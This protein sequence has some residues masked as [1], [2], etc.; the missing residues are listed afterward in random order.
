MRAIVISVLFLLVLFDAKCQSD[1][2]AINSINCD[3]LITDTDWKTDSL[4]KEVFNPWESKDFYMLLK[5][6]KVG[7]IDCGGC[8]GVSAKIQFYID[9]EGKI[10]SIK[11]LQSNKCGF[12][13]DEKFRND[14]INSFSTLV[15]PDVLRNKCYQF[16]VGRRL[17]C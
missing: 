7:K 6:H 13:F 12:P 11:L 4:M 14:F 3:T 5:K 2:L 10:Q 17:K 1:S 9:T 15:F 8:E 16:Y